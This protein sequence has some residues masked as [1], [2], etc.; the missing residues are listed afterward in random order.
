MSPPHTK[1]SIPTTQYLFSLID[2]YRPPGLLRTMTQIGSCS[3]QFVKRMVL[4]SWMDIRQM[5]KIRSVISPQ[6][7]DIFGLNPKTPG[8]MY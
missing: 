5:Q 8:F 1:F 6:Y 3:G 2:R 7:F 4:C